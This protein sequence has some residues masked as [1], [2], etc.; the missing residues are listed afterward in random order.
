MKRVICIQ[1]LT[2]LFP[3]VRIELNI[4]LVKL[5]NAI[6]ISCERDGLILFIGFLPE[7]MLHAISERKREKEGNMY[8]KVSQCSLIYIDHYNY[9]TSNK[10]SPTDI[11]IEPDIRN[12]IDIKKIERDLDQEDL[13]K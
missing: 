4:L 12:A 2:V 6:Q 7:H 1:F 10:V 5:K 11:L 9:K 8:T 13:E 3:G